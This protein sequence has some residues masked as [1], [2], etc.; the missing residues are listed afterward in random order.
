M[1]DSVYYEDHHI[2]MKSMGGTNN[3]NNR[4]KLTLREHFIA[5]WLLWRIHRNRKSA[6]AFHLM[7]ERCKKVGKVSSRSYEE[8]KIIHIEMMS[9]KNNPMYGKKQLNETIKKRVESFKKVIRGDEWNSNISKSLI[10]R[11]LSESHKDNIKKK[12]NKQVYFPKKKGIIKLLDGK[13][14]RS[15]R[16]AAIDAGTNHRNIA[17][18]IGKEYDYFYDVNNNPQKSGWKQK[19][20]TKKRISNKLKGKPQNN[21]THKRYWTS[22]EYSEEEAL[23]IIRARKSKK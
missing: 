21:P 9:G 7:A 20:E 11:N 3:R 15:M 5:H 8:S 16:E 13:I 1:D 19:T 14:F 2:V 22:L 10:G 18:K 23:E 12:R 17:S 6:Y 4:V